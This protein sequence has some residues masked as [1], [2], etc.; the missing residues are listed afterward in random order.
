MNPG[1][2]NALD[3]S[4]CEN[5]SSANPHAWLAELTR[6]QGRGIGVVK[7]GRPHNRLLP[8]DGGLTLM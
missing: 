1:L 7:G 6:W 5:V 2:F 8:V 3:A 4:A